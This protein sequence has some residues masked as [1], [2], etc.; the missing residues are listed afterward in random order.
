MC[1]L[2]KC[3]VAKWNFFVIIPTAVRKGFK[4]E[5]TLKILK[6]FISS[7]FTNCD[8]FSSGNIMFFNQK[9]VF[10]SKNANCTIVDFCVVTFHS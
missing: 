8:I 4:L 7:Y 5:G 6:S 2:H 3:F 1:K 9:W 10:Y